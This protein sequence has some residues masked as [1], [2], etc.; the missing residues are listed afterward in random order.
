M[1]PWLLMPTDGEYS[2]PSHS[3]EYPLE[4]SANASNRADFHLHSETDVSAMT[5]A[6]TS[7]GF[8]AAV[9]PFG[10]D[11]NATSIDESSIPSNVT[12]TVDSNGNAVIEYGDLC[13]SF[14]TN[15]TA[16]QCS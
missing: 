6:T 13:I 7:F 5:D 1:L 15:G 14:L 9:V 2:L 8:A 4:I 16:S 3:I 10:T 12:T 11:N